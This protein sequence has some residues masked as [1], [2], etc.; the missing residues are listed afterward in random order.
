MQLP[1]IISS[2]ASAESLSC[3]PADDPDRLSVFSLAATGGFNLVFS[4]AIGRGFALEFANGCSI[5]PLD[6]KVYCT[7]LGG[8]GQSFIIRFGDSLEGRYEFVASIAAAGVAAAFSGSGAFTVV[9]VSGNTMRQY[10]ELSGLHGYASAANS[11]LPDLSSV[12]EVS[13][14][15]MPPT[16]DIVIVTADFELRGTSSEYILSLGV[17]SAVPALYVVR[18][19]E[20]QRANKWVMRVNFA[21]GSTL[22][23]GGMAGRWSWSS[24]W[25]YAQR[26]FFG[27]DN[28]AGVY[29]VMVDTLDFGAQTVTIQHVG[30]AAASNSRIDGF[31]CVS[32][33]S[34]WSTASTT[35]PSSAL[36]AAPS[37]APTTYTPTILGQTF[38]PSVN[39]TTS[40]SSSTPSRAPSSAPTTGPNEL[41]SGQT[42]SPT[43][44]LSSTTQSP[45]STSAA[46]TNT[47]AVGNG[48]TEQSGSG[49]VLDENWLIPLAA[50]VLIGSSMFLGCWFFVLR[51]LWH[52]GVTEPR[53]KRVR[54][55]LQDSE[56][57]EETDADEREPLSRGPSL[58]DVDQ[59]NQS[60]ISR[61]SSMLSQ[62]LS[63]LSLSRGHSI[64]DD[65][66]PQE[67]IEMNR[68]DD[69]LEMIGKMDVLS[70]GELIMTNV[71]TELKRSPMHSI[72]NKSW[73][74]CDSDNDELE[75]MSREPSREEQ[76]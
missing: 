27:E 18:L 12:R 66:T 62:G 63:V 44:L 65:R 52:E 1:F 47:T 55:T 38:S 6:S 28:G 76:L 70:S 37:N 42:A 3:Q 13:V 36:T 10:S 56:A 2:C 59:D 30:P 9:E 16:L 22:G 15:D 75:S 68:L 23:S 7:G 20:N 11:Q 19:D 14:G 32:A 69:E 33:V 39:P 17:L 31:N 61:K 26:I 48:T 73:R 8:G 71:E 4:M 29:E 60:R 35:A 50:V 54:A 45:T 34:M 58:N 74:Q 25:V 43:A 41:P 46:N 51:R 53:L 21:D 64:M 5:N 24:G 40:R 49:H 67:T 57:E 72:S